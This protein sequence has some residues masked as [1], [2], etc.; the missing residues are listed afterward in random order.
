M[1]L[2]VRY[3]NDEFIARSI[4][5]AID[6]L[7]SLNIMDFDFNDVF[8]N[9]LEKF[10]DS[11]AAYPKRFK[12][13][14]HTYFLIIKT[15]AETLDEFKQNNYK[16]NDEMEDDEDSFQN[17]K[18]LKISVLSDE[19]EGWYDGTL[20]FKRVIAI[21]GTNKFQYK[22]TRF[23]A[24]CKAKSP[25]DCYNRIVEYLRNR[26]DVD[27]RSQFPSPKGRNFMFSYLGLKRPEQVNE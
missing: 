2:Y 22:D 19:I 18:K 27:L 11:D 24:Q 10:V 4:D 16:R 13:H 8:V 20:I 17:R 25:L 9:E 15:N 21:P 14:A 1:N 23:R 26:Q 12:V 3:F 7:K 6:F 5:E